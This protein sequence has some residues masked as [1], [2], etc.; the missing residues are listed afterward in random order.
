M[1]NPIVKTTV[2]ATKDGNNFLK[3]L[4]NAPTI[5]AAIPPTNCAP[6]MDAIP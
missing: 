2:P 1:I 5:I 6:N 3:G 4:I